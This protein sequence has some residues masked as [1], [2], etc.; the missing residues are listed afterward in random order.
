MGLPNAHNLRMDYYPTFSYTLW[1]ALP[2]SAR[3]IFCVVAGGFLVFSLMA[4]CMRI[5]N[6]D[7]SECHG[8]IP[9]L[10]IPF[11]L[12]SFL[13]G[14][15]YLIAEP[16]QLISY[17]SWFGIKLERKLYPIS[18]IRRWTLRTA[19]NMNQSFKQGEMTDEQPRYIYVINVTDLHGERKMLEMHHGATIRALFDFLQSNY[20]QVPCENQIDL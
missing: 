1:D 10:I 13:R 20:P 14:R 19:L 8:L 16:N 17:S 3:C 7:V 5:F 15:W 11:V 2:K 12:L 18:D 9:F 4:L 6:G